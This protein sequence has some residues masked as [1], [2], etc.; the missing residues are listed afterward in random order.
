MSAC[1][2]ALRARPGLLTTRPTARGVGL[3][4]HSIEVGALDP[5]APADPQRGQRPLV[6]PVADRLLIQLQHL[7]HLG[8][9]QK[10]VFRLP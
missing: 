2:Q 8:D 1:R 5:H 4:E 9:G 10:R 7:R 3:S 6:D